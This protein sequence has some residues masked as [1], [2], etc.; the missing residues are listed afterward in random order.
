MEDH[1]LANYR[2]EIRKNPGTMDSLPKICKDANAW[3]ADLF[4][5]VHFNAGGGD[6]FEGYV[7]NENRVP[8][9]RVFAKHVKE[10]GQNL[11]N[12]SIAPGVKIQPG[13]VVLRETTMPA[14]LLEG[15][16][17]DNKKDITDWNDDAELKALGTAYAKAAAEFLKLEPKAPAQYYAKIGPFATKAEADAVVKALR[18]ATL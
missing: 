16:F 10:A 13:F 9:G 15:A 6:G 1:L 11:R 3:G 4:V 17:V 12:S 2:C 5:S 14:V 18:T 8:L 7:H